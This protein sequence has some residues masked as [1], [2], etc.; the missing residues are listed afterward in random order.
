MKRLNTSPQL[1]PII[2][3]PTGAPVMDENTR[4]PLTKGLAINLQP[5][6]FTVDDKAQNT[7]D[8]SEYRVLRSKKM[9]EG[10]RY[11]RSS[12]YT[13]AAV[14]LLSWDE[15]CDDLAVKEEVAKL[16]NTLRG[17]FYFHTQ[18]SNLDTKNEKRLQV[19]VNLIVAN[20]I[21]TYDGPN[22]LL[23]VYYA[24]HGRPGLVLLRHI[25]TMRIAC[26]AQGGSCQR[27]WPVS[28]P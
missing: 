27:G 25:R 17:R 6:P 22:T 12:T 10:K 9:D 14:L 21:A 18:I 3:T 7:K 20:F 28:S 4:F 24:G 8:D 23:I 13:N 26:N 19:Q 15:A 11:N 1:L 16:Q 2:S 5:E